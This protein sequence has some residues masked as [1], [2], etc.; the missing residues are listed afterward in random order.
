MSI[1][2]FLIFAALTVASA[3]VVVIH[4][5][6]IYCALGL[7]S[8][9]FMLALLFIGLE[10]HMVAVL[11]IIVYAGAIV[12]LFLFVIM[13]LNLQVEER[14]TVPRPLFAVATAGGLL[15]GALVLVGIVRAPLAAPMPVHADYGGTEPLAERLFTT[16][17][18]PFELTSLLLLVAIVGAVVVGKRRA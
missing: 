8:T 11:Q 5:N 7:V 18:L 15:L 16:Y 17:L 3:L 13:L 6:P 2:L 12:V 1:P 14:A 10:A 4:R 9:L